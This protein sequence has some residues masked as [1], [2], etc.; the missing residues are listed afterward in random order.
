MRIG[1]LLVEQRKLRQSDLARA[2]AEKPA[3]KRLCSFLI[4][5][6]LVDFDDASRALGEQQG[7]PC[8]LAKHL[9]GRDERLANVIPAELGRESCALPIG[10][11]SQG[12]VIVCVRDPSASLL[13]A[14]QQATSAAIMMV[15]APANRLE[16][17]VLSAYGA[18]PTDELDVDFSTTGMGENPV[19]HP[20]SVMRAA[21]SAANAPSVPPLPDMAAL[22][23]ESVR[24]ALTDLDDARVAKDPTQSG[25]IPIASPPAPTPAP[26]PAATPAPPRLPATI[27][28]SKVRAKTAEAPRTTRP[29]SV[30]AMSVGLEYAPTREAATDLVLAYV[31]TRWR[32]GLVLAIRDTSAIGYR[33]HGVSMPELVSVP[34]AV[35]S[36]V[37]RAVVTKTASA[38]APVS[39][40]QDALVRALDGPST[41][42]AAP[43]V[44]G[45][46]AVAVIAVGDPIDVELPPEEAVAELGLLADALGTAYQRLMAR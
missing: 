15:I 1:E 43:V 22:D 29:M 44:V 34:L 7:V 2:L 28:M 4:A 6:G 10:R 17:L 42:A 46:N 36:T 14:L 26:K 38:D 30:G 20:P 24:L 8:A 18:A 35:P 33:G 13:A 25:Q 41:T 11:T 40:A 32:S 23:P 3:D 19:L 16:H 27:A 31:A 9:A 45:A 5:R 37:Q 12:A 39:A 21:A